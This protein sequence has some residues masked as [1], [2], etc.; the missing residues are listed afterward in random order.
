MLETRQPLQEMM[1]PHACNPS[2]SGGGDV[3]D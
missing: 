3:D 2:S 1:L